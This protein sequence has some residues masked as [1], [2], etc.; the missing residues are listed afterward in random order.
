LKEKIT[1]N[2]KKIICKSKNYSIFLFSKKDFPM[3][4]VMKRTGD[5]VNFDIENITIAL[6]KCYLAHFGKLTKEIKLEITTIT[7]SI[8]LEHI[9]PYVKNKST[10][11]DVVLD[12]EEIQNYVVCTLIEFGKQVTVLS[13]HL[14]SNSRT[15]LNTQVV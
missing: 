1:K 14:T 2:N 13:F 6:G 15:S 11:N 4:K 10:T 7:S 12:I 9:L 3:I 8:Y 5:V